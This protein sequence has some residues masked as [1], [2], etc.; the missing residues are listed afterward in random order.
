MTNTNEGRRWWYVPPGDGPRCRVVAVDGCVWVRGAQGAS[1][2]LLIPVPPVTGL[3]S[4]LCG[5][6]SMVSGWAW[7]S[8]FQAVGSP[9]PPSALRLGF[10]HSLPQAGQVRAIL[11]GIGLR[12]VSCDPSPGRLM[13]S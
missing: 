1:P 2:C 3:I 11:D 9:V 10:D 7:G 6:G 8:A 13:C 4:A 5:A 12:T